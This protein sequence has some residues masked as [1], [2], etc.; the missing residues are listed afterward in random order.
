MKKL[1]ISV[2]EAAALLGVHEKTVRRAV[3]RGELPGK[4]LRSRV[5]I[6]VAALRAW[7]EPDT[8]PPPPASPA[9]SGR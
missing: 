5:L 8:P 6:P 7:I 9:G 2:K 4:K 1:V 3:A